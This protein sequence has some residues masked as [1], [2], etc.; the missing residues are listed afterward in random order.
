MPW[1]QAVRQEGR[2]ANLFPED[3]SLA[4]IQSRKSK[5]RE[6]ERVQAKHG[7]TQSLHRTPKI[8]VQRGFIARRWA[9]RPKLKWQEYIEARCR[10]ELTQGMGLWRANRTMEFSHRCLELILECSQLQQME[11][12]RIP[13]RSSLQLPPWRRSFE[14]RRAKAR[15]CSSKLEESEAC[16]RTLATSTSRKTPQR[17]S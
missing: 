4:R 17:A 13:A 14:V 15:T 11:E 8:V 3:N 7:T 6:L 9:I 16:S 1:V 12:R 5:A 10:W 2:R